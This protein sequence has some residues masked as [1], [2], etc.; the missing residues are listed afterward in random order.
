MLGLYVYYNSSA[1]GPR[2]AMWQVY[3]F[4]GYANNVECMHTSADYSEFIKAIYIDIVVS[5]LHMS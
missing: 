3:L 4:G 2:Y 5:R 1:M